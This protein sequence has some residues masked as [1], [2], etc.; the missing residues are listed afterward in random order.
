MLAPSLRRPSP[1]AN[2]SLY[3]ETLGEGIYPT[4]VIGIVGLLKTAAP[5][6][7]DFKKPGRS[8][9]LLGG[10]GGADEVRFGGT[11][12]VK[13]VLDNLWGLPPALDMEHEKRVQSA[14]REIVNL[15]PR[16]IRARP[17]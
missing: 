5:V 13:A 3:N 16:R 2:V 12:Y 14:I 8:V 11:T 15:R 4:P 17:F 9:M 6:T 10:I 1:A 7:I